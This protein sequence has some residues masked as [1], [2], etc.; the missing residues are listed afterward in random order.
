MNVAEAI[1][2][3]FAQLGVN[4]CFCVTGGGAMFLNDAFDQCDDIHVVY[5]H[6]EQASAISAE[7]Y[8]RLANKPAIVN[9]TTGPGVTNSLTGVHGAYTDSI[10]MI[11]VSGQVKTATSARHVYG[12]S[13]AIRQ[14]GDQEV[15]VELLA[16]PIVKH[17]VAVD[18]AADLIHKIDNAFLLATTGRPG[19]VWLDVPI[20]VQQKQVGFGLNTSSAVPKLLVNDHSFEYPKSSHTHLLS[21]VRG[22]VSALQTALRPVLLVGGGVRL[23][24]M[25]SELEKLLDTWSLPT[26]VAWSAIDAVSEHHPCYAGRP[27]SV[28]DRYGN[29]VVESSDLLI[30]LGCRLNIRQIG[31]EFHSYATNARILMIDIDSREL[32]K[33]TLDLHAAIHLDI[34]DFLPLLRKELQSLRQPK[35]H[36]Q[37]LSRCKKIEDKYSA[38]NEKRPSSGMSVYKFIEKLSTCW[39]SSDTIVCGNGSACVVTFQVAHT[40]SGIRMFTN[41]GSASMGYDLPAAIGASAATVGRVWC[42][43]GDGS[44]MMNIQELQTIVHH[45]KNIIIVLLS[46]AG[47]SSIRMSQRRFFSRYSGCDEPSGLSF[48]DYQKVFDAFGLTK[49]AEIN[50]ID[51]LDMPSLNSLTGPGYI[52]ANLSKDEDFAPKVSSKKTANGH[53]TSSRM[54]DMAPHL[55]DRRIADVIQW[56]TGQSDRLGH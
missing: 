7:G 29:F 34:K 1:V 40:P 23:A 31:Y 30:I 12:T 36:L 22:V 32:S 25:L 46:N 51:E 14:L 41:S 18:S 38:R 5:N 37:Y 52:I 33:P 49:I 45:K 27:G 17:F 26:A 3:R 13:A 55:S 2:M 44:I 15:P 9:V 43:A 21:E 53:I 24:G 4:Q 56:L 48:P 39:V 54:H 19:P 16:T 35:S 10:P 50:G 8:A 20:D 11:V 42:I 28:G 6:H 47:Y